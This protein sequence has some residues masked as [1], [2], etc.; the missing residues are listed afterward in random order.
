MRAW[1]QLVQLYDRL[2]LTNEAY[3]A[4]FTAANVLQTTAGPMLKLC[5]LDVGRTAWKSAGEALDQAATADPADPRLAAY[6]GVIAQQKDQAGDAAAWF[7]AAAA[8]NNAQAQLKGLR[9]SESGG[10]LLPESAGLTLQLNLLAGQLALDAGRPQQ[11]AALLAASLPLYDRIAQADRYKPVISAM[12][13]APQDQSGLVPEAPNVETLL[14]WT[15]LRRGEA[16][17][18]LGQPD[19]AARDWQWAMDFETRKPAVLD[20]G[21]AIRQPATLAA[22]DMLK[23]VFAKG[24]IN[25]ARLALQRIGAPRDLPPAAQ[26]ELQ[27]LQKQI[28]T[29]WQQ[30]QQAQLRQAM[31]MSPAD[32]RR[33]ALL[34]ERDGL[35][36]QKQTIEQTLNDPKASDREKQLA[37]GSIDQLNQVINNLN[38][39][40]EQSGR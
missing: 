37:R 15:R 36:R 27:Q 8:I 21:S 2:N 10:P 19:E 39:E 26:A 22:I 40:L 13:P 31:N 32:A 14:C 20:V 29:A 23:V 34:N 7:A 25:A 5:W 30:G 11:A 16:L 24:D 28:D 12:L 9:L 33:Q 3:Q 17:A 4:R 35:L 18:K 1:Q 38:R 6:R